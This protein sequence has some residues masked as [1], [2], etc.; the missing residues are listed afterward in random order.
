[1]QKAE[2]DNAQS[3]ASISAREERQNPTENLKGKADLSGFQVLRKEFSSHK[4]DAAVTISYDCITFNS[5]CIR[6]YPDTNYVQI[7]IDEKNRRI[8]IR[9]CGEWDRNAMQWARNQKKDDKRV[10]RPIKA[11]VACARL[12]ELMGWDRQNRYK[13]LGTRKIYENADVVIF[14]MEEAEIF[15]TETETADDGKVKRK[16]RNF[17]PYQW[18]DSFGD[19]VEEHDR[20]QALDMSTSFTL[21]NTP[22]GQAYF[23]KPKVSPPKKE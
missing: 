15:T 12:F 13:M 14:M 5:A 11:Q 2:K 4:F 17:L 10:S 22:D 20:K 6:F 23:V 18:R 19:Y 9:K 16:S 8:A 1:M 21:F 7:L 3:P